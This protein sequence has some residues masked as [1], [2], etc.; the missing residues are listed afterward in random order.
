MSILFVPSLDP[1]MHSAHL[2]HM[3][4]CAGSAN[5][6]VL[7]YLMIYAGAKGMG[8][9]FSGREHGLKHS[10]G[11]HPLPGETILHVAARHGRHR[12][13]ERFLDWMPKEAIYVENRFENLPCSFALFGTEQICFLHRWPP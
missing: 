1:V 12:C 13:L 2:P 5:L 3:P 9:D 4:Y 10:H 6:N 11:T 8:E 7:K